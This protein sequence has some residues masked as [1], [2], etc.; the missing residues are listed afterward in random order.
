MEITITTPYSAVTFDMAPEKVAAILKE[1]VEAACPTTPPV[2]VKAPE[3]HDAELGKTMKPE[4]TQ[5]PE[6]EPPKQRLVA[7]PSFTQHIK[8]NKENAGQKTITFREGSRNAHLF[9]ESAQ[10]RA[11]DPAQDGYKGFL[12][13]KCEHCGKVRGL[14]AKIP[15]KTYRCKECGKETGLKDL[16]TVRFKC[17]CGRSYKYL[18]NRQEDEFDWECLDCGTSTPIVWNGRRKQYQGMYDYA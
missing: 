6:P 14:C 16:A 18:T 3:E 7:A 12:M 1:A 17:K 2:V 4:P 11:E 15:T 13:I 8:E 5:K 9:G 10:V